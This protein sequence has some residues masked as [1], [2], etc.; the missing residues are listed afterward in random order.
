MHQ[1]SAPPS[2]RSRGGHG[3]RCAQHFDAFAARA[4]G[5]RPRRMGIRASTGRSALGRRVKS[6]QIM[7]LKMCARS[8]A[9]VSGSACTWIGPQPC[10]ARTADHAVGEQADRQHMVEVRMAD[11]DVVDARQRFKRQVADTGAGVDQHVVGRAGRRWSC[12]PRRWRR[13]S[14]GLGGSWT[15]VGAGRGRVHR[16]EG[17][18]APGGHGVNGDLGGACV[19][20][21]KVALAGCLVARRRERGRAA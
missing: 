10:E 4:P 2:S 16:A 21:A 13:S 19:Q 6:G 1:P 17:R 7:P 8:A 15:G 11:Q 20:G 12:N 9:I 18:V 14:R 5:C 3:V